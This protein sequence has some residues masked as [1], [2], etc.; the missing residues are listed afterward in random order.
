MPASGEHGENVRKYEAN[1]RSLKRDYGIFCL[2]LGALLRETEK[3]EY[4]NAIL[5]LLTDEI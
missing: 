5:R 3:E 2:E 1:L 4:V